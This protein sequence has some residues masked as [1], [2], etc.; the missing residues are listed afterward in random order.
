MPKALC[1]S[2]MI[3]SGFILLL[4]GFDLAIKISSL[5]EST[6]FDSA[7][8]KKA[9]TFRLRSERGGSLR[10]PPIRGHRR[11][12]RSPLRRRL[13]RARVAARQQHPQL[14]RQ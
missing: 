4:F 5:K 7:H 3:V 6:L 1:L 13:R 12:Q 10:L 2:G 11:D 9:R 8:E 14:V